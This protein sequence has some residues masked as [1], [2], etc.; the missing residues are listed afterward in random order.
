MDAWKTMT[1]LVICAALMVVVVVVVVVVV[2]VLMTTTTMTT[3][4]DVDDGDGQDDG[5]DDDGG[6]CLACVRVLTTKI[7]SSSI[8]AVCSQVKRCLR[9]V[10]NTRPLDPSWAAA[11]ATATTA[12]VGV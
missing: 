9:G 3:H 12:R 11:V 6:G 4:G 1:M 2:A 8:L 10:G 5:D 7:I